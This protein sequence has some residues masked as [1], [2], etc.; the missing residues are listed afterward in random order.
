MKFKFYVAQ[1][2]TSLPQ[3]GTGGQ[4]VH[5]EGL[6]SSP[7]SGATQELWAE[8][9]RR[10]NTFLLPVLHIRCMLSSGKLNFL[11]FLTCI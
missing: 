5:G 11:L 9:C 1:S 6:G 10:G 7:C 3:S 4:D 8:N 2:T